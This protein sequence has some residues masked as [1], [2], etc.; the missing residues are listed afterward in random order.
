V[1][2]DVRCVYSLGVVGSLWGFPVLDFLLDLCV[3]CVLLLVL[4]VF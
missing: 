3:I 4:C 1:V 2:R